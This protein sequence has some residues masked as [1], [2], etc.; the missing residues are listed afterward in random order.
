MYYLDIFP[1]YVL[2]DYLFIRS[3][4]FAFKSTNFQ[5][6]NNSSSNVTTLT[7]TVDTFHVIIKCQPCCLWLWVVLKIMCL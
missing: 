7:L 2:I 3:V 6:C 1:L 4:Y 5:M